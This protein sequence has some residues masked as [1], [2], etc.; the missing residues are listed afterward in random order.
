MNVA[1]II[2]TLRGG[3]AERIAGLLSKYLCNRY[4]V[5]IFVEKDSDAIYDYGGTKIVLSGNGKSKAKTLREL[6]EKY[7]ID[8]AIS[9]MD[10]GN[11]LNMQSQ[12]KE[13]VIFSARTTVSQRTYA[14]RMKDDLKWLNHSADHIV[15]VSEGCR[16]DLIRN[17]G[18]LPDS[19]TTIYN[20]LDK[21]MILRKAMQDSDESVL[22]FKGNSKLVLHVGRLEKVKNQ[23][24]LLAQFSKLLCQNDVKLLVIGSGPEEKHLH[25]K[26]N[27]LGITGMVMILPYQNNPFCYYKYADVFVLTSKVE[28]MPNVLLESMLLKTP[29]VSIDCMSGPR[30][31]IAEESD[32]GRE[33]RG[34]EICNNGILVENADTDDIGETDYLCQ[35]LQKV[36]VDDEVRQ[37]VIHNAFRF[38]ETY[39]N[40]NILCKWISVIE[41]TVPK[42]TSDKSRILPSLRDKNKVI[43]YGAGKIGTE[44]ML[45][46]LEERSDWDFICFAVTDSSACRSPIKDIPVFELKDLYEHKEDAVVVIAVGP[47]YEDEVLKNIQRH[48]FPYLWWNI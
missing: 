33:I 42:A 26:I 18:V 27:E 24:K 17:Y 39:S 2:A 44:V 38:M 48:G 8:C 23:D 28:G 36:L 29:V 1:I 45:C 20:F 4:N 15:A 37:K 32:Y 21:E 30:E 9:F 16:Y 13:A 34:Y 35:A 40:E 43:V 3:G 46:L 12:E 5:Y 47:R 22:R 7:R 25:A 31:L 6:K 19:V 41:N 11:L 10:H 14:K